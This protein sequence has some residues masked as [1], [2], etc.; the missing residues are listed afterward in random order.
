MVLRGVR[1]DFSQLPERPWVERTRSAVP[2]ICAAGFVAAASAS[3]AVA[4]GLIGPR[5]VWAAV[6]C[7]VLAGVCTLSWQLHRP[8]SMLL[9]LLGCA[10]A[11]ISG[12]LGAV[13][14]QQLGR[15]TDYSRSVQAVYAP[16]ESDPVSEKLMGERMRLDDDRSRWNAALGDPATS[17]QATLQLAAIQA[18]IENNDR[19]REAATALSLANRKVLR[20]AVPAQ[21][22]K[23]AAASA[24]GGLFAA[25]AYATLA[26]GCLVVIFAA[27]PIA[28][29]RSGRPPAGGNPRAL[30]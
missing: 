24:R 18:A 20:A 16:A 21:P 23:A 27:W 22:G 26:A 8:R 6:A 2:W 4:T 12:V 29:A 17:M 15:A 28:A 3:V 13:S 5:P 7:V 25:L 14:L 30:S 10:A 1:P 11:A 9:A 19:A